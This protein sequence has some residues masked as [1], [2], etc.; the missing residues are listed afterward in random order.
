MTAPL[1]IIMLD[2]AFPRPP[3]DV[4]NAASWPFPVLYRTVSGATARMVVNG[5]DG[6]LLEAFVA[7]GEDLRRAGACALTTSCGFLV[8]RQPVLA[9][10][11]ALPVATSSL[12]QVPWVAATLPPGRRVGVITYD[13]GSLGDAHFAAAGVAVRPPVTGLSRG[14]AFHGMIEGGQPY[15]RAALAAELLAAA[16]GLIRSA[17]DIGA[18]V[19]ECTNLPPFSA[20][21]TAATGLPV[22]DILTL[23]RWL[24]AAAAP[25][26]RSGAGV[27]G[28]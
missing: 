4:G 19:L 18:L 20:L 21:L 7:A 28:N 9:A 25:P 17:P 15:D 8:L 27:E 23:G 11:L 1:G 22:Y 2:T 26:V 10:R 12:L 13:A 14:G 24:H 5:Q 6:P 16:Q 3:G